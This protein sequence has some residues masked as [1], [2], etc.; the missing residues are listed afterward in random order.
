[1]F[2]WMMWINNN[3]LEL[4][5]GR[6]LFVRQRGLPHPGNADSG[7]TRVIGWPVEQSCDWGLPL[8]DGSRVH[9]Q[10][11]TTKEGTPVYGIHRDRWDPSR[12]LA[13]ALKHLVLET[14]AG[15]VGLVGA[16]LLGF[17]AVV[18]AAR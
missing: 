10:C 12:G 2:E 18:K 6:K 4:K 16:S 8:E 13:S 3:W 17:V 11:F 14:P 9:V 15:A 7:F 1:M 5:K